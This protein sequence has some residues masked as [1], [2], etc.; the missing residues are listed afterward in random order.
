MS[1]TS[2]EANE[3]LKRP[4]RCDWQKLSPLERSTGQPTT[5]A[6]H[7]ILLKVSAPLELPIRRESGDREAARRSLDCLTIAWTRDGLPVEHTLDQLL[8]LCRLS[9]GY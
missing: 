9:E 3:Y 8:V 4:P 6:P 2:L 5:E 1:V 7:G